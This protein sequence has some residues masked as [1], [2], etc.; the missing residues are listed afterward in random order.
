MASKRTLSDGTTWWQLYSDSF[1]VPGIVLGLL[2]IAVNICAP[3]EWWGLS[4]NTWWYYGIAGF[5][6][7][8]SILMLIENELSFRDKI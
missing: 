2:F 1:R 6:L 3:M 7:I 5:A 4:Y 8:I